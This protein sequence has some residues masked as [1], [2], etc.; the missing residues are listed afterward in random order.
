MRSAW[1]RLM[2][3]WLRNRLSPGCAA[4]TPGHA[5][6]QAQE[7]E[8]EPIR[9][10]RESVVHLANGRLVIAD[11]TEEIADRAL[12]CHKK[13]TSVVVPSTVRRIGCS[14]FADCEN[15]E[16][17]ILHEGLESVGDNAFSG[18]RKLKSLIIP[19]GVRELG[20]RAFWNS[21][22][23]E[24]VL[25]ASGDTLY[26][27]PD[28]AAG[29]AYT[30]PECVRRIGPRAFADCVHLQAVRMPESL[31]SIGDMAFVGCPLVS[32][33]IPAGATDL[34]GDIFFCCKHLKT[35]S[36][37]EEKDPIRFAVTLC[38][39]RG[40]TFLTPVRCAL[41]EF[42]R[43]WK[44]GR[45]RSLAKQCGKGSVP[46]MEAMAAFFEKKH[47]ASPETDFYRFA[48]HFWRYR[49]YENGSDA[50]RQWLMNWLAESSEEH[51]PSVCLRE[52][53][54]GCG[55]GVALN[56]LGF[57]FFDPQRSYTLYGRDADGVVQVSSYAGEDGPDEDGFGREIYDDWW[58][59]DDRLQPVPGAGC[60]QGYS[61]IER[62]MNGIIQRFQENHDA[63]AQAIR[64]RK[65]GP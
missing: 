63:V 9:L 54:A 7:K 17:V 65:E 23:T 55:T 31:E 20:G 16:E 36:L 50:Q 30:V 15:L 42:S 11:G 51:L 19:D 48:A 49:A 27:C 2:D 3:A 43:Y 10:T 28:A 35:I 45:F 34:G 58:H 44:H 12:A 47:R 38:R 1:M 13:M 14:A 24:P 57:L 8:R 60:L 6:A 40:Q 39:L 18:C 32:V 33:E 22:L 29:E 46:A 52:N 21:G 59:L 37:P 62:R 53:L 61:S 25:N 26:Y 4:N 56:A 41:P 5:S 64:K